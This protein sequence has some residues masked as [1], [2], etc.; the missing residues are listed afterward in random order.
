VVKSPTHPYKNQIYL[1]PL[2]LPL[3]DCKFGPSLIFKDHILSDIE[4]N[5]QV[6][7]ENQTQDG[8]AKK[9]TPS[10]LKIAHL[11]IQVCDFI[12]CLQLGLK[13]RSVLFVP[14]VLHNYC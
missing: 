10:M 1:L 9:N 13:R 2:Y 6:D 4:V 14:P 3:K 11:G 12:K 5:E 8:G 7:E